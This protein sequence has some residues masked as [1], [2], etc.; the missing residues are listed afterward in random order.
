M[1]DMFMRVNEAAAAVGIAATTVKKYTGLIEKLGYEF[2]RNNQGALIF[3]NSDIEMLR[4]IVQL[5]KKKNVTLEEAIK[6]VLSDMV[7]IE[8][9][10]NT[11]SAD[12]VDM[13][14]VK[15]MARDMSNM[16]VMM[17]TLIKQNEELSKTV[18]RIQE[19]N[20]REEERQLLLTQSLKATLEV[21]KMLIAQQEAA[22]TKE[23][24]PFK[25]FL[26]R[27]FNL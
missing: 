11:S 16:A 27:L 15:N 7:E 10:S 1:S 21:K 18:N 5:K 20:K 2:E 3:S 24:D 13:S 22:P 6:Q 9:V 17:D 14:A 4:S 12:I 26:R 19:G 8:D 25:N 23:G